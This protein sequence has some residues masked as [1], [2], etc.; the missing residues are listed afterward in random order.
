MNNGLAATNAASTTRLDF[1][2]VQFSSVRTSS[3]LVSPAIICLVMC[4]Q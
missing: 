3:Y 2:T 1:I 4:L